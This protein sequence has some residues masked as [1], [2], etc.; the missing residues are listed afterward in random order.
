MI[1][2]Y[3]HRHGITA[4]A[5]EQSALLHIEATLK[6]NG[7]SCSQ[8]GLP[9]IDNTRIMEAT[10]DFD[11]AHEE[12]EAITQMAKLNDEQRMLVDGVIQDLDEIR[13][14][15]AARSRTYFLDGPGGSGKT[16]CYNTLISY[17]RSQGVKVVSSSWTGIAAT[18]LRGGR[19]CQSF[20]ASC[21]H[22]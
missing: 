10:P 1:E 8:L 14:G 9:D 22:S 5:A 13:N 3:L 6:E 11:I 17:C 15:N 18:L 19:T 16:M 2:D 20:Q 7:M 12:M 4:R 21:A